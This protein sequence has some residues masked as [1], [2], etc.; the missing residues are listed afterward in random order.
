M[1]VVGILVAKIR[2]KNGMYH[3]MA[4]VFKKRMIKFVDSG[5]NCYF[6]ALF[7]NKG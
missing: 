4:A 1:I 6:C 5:N 2:I 3:E 7:I